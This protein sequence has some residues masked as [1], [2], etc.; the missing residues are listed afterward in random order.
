MAATAS[1]FLDEMTTS[2]PPGK[3]RGEY[4]MSALSRFMTDVPGTSLVAWTKSGS[5]KSPR[6][7]ATAIVRMC[8]RMVASPAE[9]LSFL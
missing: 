6:L 7:K 1:G 9:S 5:A 2:P 3:S 8:V 4:V